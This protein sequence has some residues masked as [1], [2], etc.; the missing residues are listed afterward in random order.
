MKFWR[1]TFAA[2]AMIALPAGSHAEVSE[3]RIPLGAG[4]FGF[5]PLLIMQ[6]DKLIEKYAAEAGVSVTV[7][8]P[9]LGGASVMNDILL[10]GEGHI[11]SAGPPAFIT[12]WDRTRA[13]LN[14]KGI[15]AISTLP[16][17]ITARAAELKRLDDISSDQ[18]I[19]VAGVK[20]SIASTLMQMYALK[21]YGK[22]QVYRFDA[23]TVNTT[24]PD[25]VIALL[26]GRNN[27]VAHGS[28]V[29]F[30]FRELKDPNIKTILSSYDIVGGPATFT[31]MST[32][33]KFYNENP[34]IMSAVM[35]ALTRAQQMIGE[36]KREAAQILLDSMGGKGWSIDELVEILN[37]PTTIYT[38]KPENVLAY[39]DFM[40][41]VGSI[42]HKP[43]TL[44]ELFFP[45]SAIANGN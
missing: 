23:Y 42:K 5:L 43:N 25:A 33:M 4:G 2:L 16:V 14:V 9:K 3:L 37:D 24:H 41:Q 1:A 27:V 28:S 18:K 40:Y 39:A 13:N 8:W 44:D 32:T 11:I 34:K 19:G 29:P 31:M 26:T 7:S 21:K 36:N 30:D 38:A 35:K 45:S 20:V 10:S 22:D 15:A 12:L 17:R 6:K